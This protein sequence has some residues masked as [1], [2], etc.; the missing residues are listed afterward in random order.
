MF[1]YRVAFVLWK[2]FVRPFKRSSMRWCA[3]LFNKDK[4]FATEIGAGGRQLPSG[5]LRPG[6]PIGYLCRRGLEIE[7]SEFKAPLKLVGILGRWKEED[8]VFYYSGEVMPSAQLSRRYLFV[9]RSQLGS[10]LPE[11]IVAQVE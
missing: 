9:D 6:Y 3:I 7:P 10:L 4:Q 11:E 2:L 5:M 8:V 1:A